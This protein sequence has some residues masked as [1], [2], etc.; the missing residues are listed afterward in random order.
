MRYGETLL[1]GLIFV[2]KRCPACEGAFPLRVWDPVPAF[3]TGYFETAVFKV[4]EAAAMK[5]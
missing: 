1:P 2:L 5:T 4:I 3:G